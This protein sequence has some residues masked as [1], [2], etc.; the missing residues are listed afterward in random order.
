[1]IINFKLIIKKYLYFLFPAKP[2]LFS[3][4]K[5]TTWFCFNFSKTIFCFATG[6]C[7]F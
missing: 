1:M 2:S 6:I 4:K 3:E 7:Q 5:K